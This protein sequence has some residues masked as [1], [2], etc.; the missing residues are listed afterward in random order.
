MGLGI[1]AIAKE[2]FFWVPLMCVLRTHIKFSIFKNI[3][4]KLKKFSLLFQFLKKKKFQKKKLI[5]TLRTHFSKIQSFHHAIAKILK[6]R[7]ASMQHIHVG[8]HYLSR[9]RND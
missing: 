6:R 8:P 1:N 7:I 9:K 3:F 5:F 4:Q 2:Y